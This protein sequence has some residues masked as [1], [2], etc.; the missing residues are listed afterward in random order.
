MFSFG[1][2]RPSEPTALCFNQHL[3]IVRHISYDVNRDCQPT[4]H[5]IIDILG[6][7]PQGTALVLNAAV[8][9]VGVRYAR[10]MYM[11][12]SFEAD[13]KINVSDH[14]ARDFVV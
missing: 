14:H 10:A 7:L 11:L 12:F 4:K 9:N 3:C 8:V 2:W 13:P 1:T 6:A 5:H